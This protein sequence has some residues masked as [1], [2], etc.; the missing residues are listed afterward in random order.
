M[1][2]Y[3]VP[4]PALLIP[5]KNI[6]VSAYS[7][8]TLSC[9]GRGF[10]DVKVVWTKPPSEVTTT[11]LYATERYDDK[12]VSTLTIHRVVEIYSG[13]YCCAV[14]NHVGS[15]E[16]QCASLKVNSKFKGM[17][18][19]VGKAQELSDYSIFMQSFSPI[20]S[21]QC[22][23]KAKPGCFRCLTGTPQIALIMC[24]HCA[25]KNFSETPAPALN[26]FD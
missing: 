24:V 6:T 2:L 5:P 21:I 12:I 15:S 1:Y 25:N 13:I 20:D 7:K 4:P 10:G 17:Y 8:V 14:I 19:S 16:V 3:L 9:T 23:F 18:V 11:A 22:R 26:G